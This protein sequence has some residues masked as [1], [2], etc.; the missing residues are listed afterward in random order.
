MAADRNPDDERL[1][2]VTGKPLPDAEVIARRSADIDTKKAKNSEHVKVITVGP[3]DKPTEKT[4]NFD[5]DKAA[6]RQYAIS[7]G[8]RPVGDVK[9]SSIEKREGTTNVWDI[10][11]TLPVAVDERLEEASDPDIVSDGPGKQ[12][13]D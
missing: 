5:S 12:T 2:E 11:Y 4:Y 8:M 1:D 3:M 13:T 10:T 6:V 9:V 7:G